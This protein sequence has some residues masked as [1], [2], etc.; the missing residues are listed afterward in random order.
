MTFVSIIEGSVE[1]RFDV[2]EGYKPVVNSRGY[3]ELVVDPD[4]Q[5]VQEVLPVKTSREQ[6]GQRALVLATQTEPVHN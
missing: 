6:I 2:P 5:P 4:Y 3:G 1:H